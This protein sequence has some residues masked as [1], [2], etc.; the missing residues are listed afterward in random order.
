MNIKKYDIR[1]GLGWLFIFKNIIE[2]MVIDKGF[3]ILILLLMDIVFIVVLKKV[4]LI[5]LIFLLY[6]IMAANHEYGHYRMVKKLKISNQNVKLVIM[7]KKYYITYTIDIQE[8]I[9]DAVVLVRFNAI[10]YDILSVIIGIVLYIVSPL[11]VLSGLF[12]M[13][14]I[15]NFANY[16]ILS[17]GSDGFIIYQY[18]NEKG[19]YKL[20]DLI[21]KNIN[22]KW[23]G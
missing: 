22:Y 4:L 1:E 7:K 8:N 19:V 13:I 17:E 20:F 9:D 14:T 21:I 11:K 5:V 3:I 2:H 18:V 10:F 15:F 23:S 12:I 16:F 6:C